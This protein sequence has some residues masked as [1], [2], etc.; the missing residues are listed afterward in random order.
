MS[1]LLYTGSGPYCYSSSLAMMLGEGAPS[2]GVVEVLTGAPFGMALVAGKLPFFDP[3]G[4]DPELGLD[5]AISL[6]GWRCRFDSGGDE[7]GALRRLRGAVDKGPV[8]VGPVEMGMFRHQP[9]MDGPIGADHYVVVLE[10]GDDQVLMH[11]PQGYPF[12]TLPLPLFL[13]AWRAESIPFG[14]PYSMRC[15]FVRDR[16]VAVDEALRRAIPNA[17]AF[18]SNRDD[19]PVPAGTVGAGA[20][21]LALADLLIEDPDPELRAHL[22]HF[23]IRVGARRLS[24][25]AAALRHLDLG[26]AADVAAAQARLVGALQYDVVT[27]DNASAAATLRRLAP[28]Y[29]TLAATLS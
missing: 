23:A 19:L 21:A 10:V 5:T 27:G 3:Y 8:L 18:L 2:P 4:W 28:T 15:E 26:A 7:A 17:V 22:V 16:D 14:A 1:G 6:L 9:G 11:D 20:A 25:A 13:S 29:E 24:D 12:A